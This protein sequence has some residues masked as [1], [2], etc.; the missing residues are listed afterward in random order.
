[1]GKRSL[2]TNTDTGQDETKQNLQTLEFVKGDPAKL[3]DKVC[4]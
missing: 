3:D 4:A 2:G 1:M